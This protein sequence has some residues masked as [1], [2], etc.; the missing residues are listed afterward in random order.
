VTADDA[1]KT[2]TFTGVSVT[3]DSLRTTFWEVEGTGR[4][5]GSKTFVVA[6]APKHI[7]YEDSIKTYPSFLFGVDADGNITPI[8]ET[9]RGG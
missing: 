1:T 9:R 4:V 3:I 2:V 8:A 6:V 7:V 5:T